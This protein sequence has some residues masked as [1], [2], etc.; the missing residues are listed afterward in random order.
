MALLTNYDGSLL[1]SGWPSNVMT[2]TGTNSKL[3]P[4]AD[5]FS[6][7]S[8]AHVSDASGQGYYSNYM[9]SPTLPPAQ[10][11][12][13]GLP[14]H[15]HH[16]SGAGVTVAPMPVP[17]AP[18]NGNTLSANL[19]R[20][21]DANAN[22]NA[23]ANAL[24]LDT[25]TLT[26]SGSPRTNGYPSP[27]FEFSPTPG[28]THQTVRTPGPRSHSRCSSRSSDGL[29]SGLTS[30]VVTPGGGSPILPI[31]TALGGGGRKNSAVANGTF[32][33]KKTH[34][35]PYEACERHTRTF[36]SNADLQ[37]H[38]RSHKGEKPHKCPSHD[39][40]KAYGQQN[41]MVKHVESQHPHLLP[42]VELGRT[43]TRR[44][45]LPRTVNVRHVGVASPFAK[46]SALAY[47][48]PSTPVQSPPLTTA[49]PSAGSLYNSPLNFAHSRA[50]PYPPRSGHQLHQMARTHSTGST[51]SASGLGAGFQ[52]PPSFGSQYCASGSMTWWNPT[53]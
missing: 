30:V 25:A 39:C 9:D 33:P 21:V 11:F 48:Y 22:A 42:M 24:Q 6:F 52:L 23:G 20:V 36:R 46:P 34:M 45:A 13:T 8:V 41:K 38:I 26:P 27:S 19:Q 43:R 50:A 29:A 51:G 14:T 49:P 4:F 37:R 53:S 18:I 44:T 16:S 5:D 17:P 2:A 35:C 28:L 12:D 15:S 32:I 47:S 3:A 7:E 1:E 10:V 40:Q 31:R